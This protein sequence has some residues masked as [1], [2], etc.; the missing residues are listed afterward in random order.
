[1]KSLSGYFG[2][3]TELDAGVQRH[4]RNPQSDAHMPA[5]LFK[6][7][8]QEI[9]G[10]VEN[11]RMVAK[12]RSAVYIAFETHDAADFLEIAIGGCLELRDG[13]QSGLAGRLVAIFHGYLAAQ[14]AGV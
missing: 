11:L 8:Q 1:M 9:G 2:P 4:I 10:A 3:D 12:S 7:F 5:A 6:Y 14:T 13:I